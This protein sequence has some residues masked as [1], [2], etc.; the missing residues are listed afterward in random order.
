M[1]QH[2]YLWVAVGAIA[3]YLAYKAYKKQAAA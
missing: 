1:K 3:A 2:H